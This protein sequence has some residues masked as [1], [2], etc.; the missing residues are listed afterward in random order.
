MSRIKG[1]TA[2]IVLGVIML[3]T[4]CSVSMAAESGRS[5]TK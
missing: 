1:I 5:D 4:P 2:S 3:V